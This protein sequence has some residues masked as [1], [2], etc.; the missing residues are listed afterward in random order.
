MERALGELVV[1]GIATNQAFQRRLLGDPA[2]RRSDIDI[3]Y[4]ER[5]QHLIAGAPDEAREVGIAIAAALAEHDRRDQARPA[6]AAM[7][8]AP[9]AWLS[10]GRRDGLR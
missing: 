5:N 7:A 6:V 2:F 4:L 3:Q 10:S 8:D 1:T 9:S